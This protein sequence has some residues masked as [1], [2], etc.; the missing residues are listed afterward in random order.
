MAI[1]KSTQKSLSKSLKKRGM[2]RASDIEIQ[3]QVKSLHNSLNSSLSLPWPIFH[4][5]IVFKY[6]F[7]FLI[8]SQEVLPEY[9]LSEEHQ[10]TLYLS[11]KRRK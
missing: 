11:G 7:S 5:S 3:Q 8:S 10:T 9:V 6:G 4:G 1:V 2:E